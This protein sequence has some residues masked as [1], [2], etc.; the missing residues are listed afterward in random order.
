MLVIGVVVTGVHRAVA[1]FAP[2]VAPYGFAQYKDD[3]GNRFEK[4]APPSS[5]HWFGTDDLSDRRACRA[6]SGAR[7]R[8]SRWSTLSV[9]VLGDHRAV[10]GVIS[11]YFGGWLDRWLVLIMDALFAFPSFLLAVVFAFLF[12]DIIGDGHL[13]HQ[14]RRRRRGAVAD[15]HLHPAVLPGRAQHHGQR[16]AGD[17]H[18][19]GAR[20]R[21]PAT[22]GS[23]AGTCSAT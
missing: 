20:A 16:E 4:L 11:G 6:S 18:R 15:L 23:C 8:R 19:G 10:L 12:T 2:W 13:V 21:A 1:I 14:G 9:I 17:L 3:D 7:S 5:D 22:A